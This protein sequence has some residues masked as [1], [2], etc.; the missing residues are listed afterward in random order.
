MMLNKKVAPEPRKLRADYDVAF[1][2]EVQKPAALALVVVLCPADCLLNPAVN[3]EI[4][5]FAEIADFKTLVFDR[6][7]VA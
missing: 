6:L 5:S 3:A 2:H 1:L 7:P 4:L